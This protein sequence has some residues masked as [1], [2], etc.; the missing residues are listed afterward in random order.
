[1][2]TGTVKWFDPAKGFGF[3]QPEDGSKDVFVHVTAVH[4]AGMD[5]LSEG[6]RVNFE[7]VTERAPSEA[8]REMHGGEFWEDGYFART[9][10]DEVTTE[11]IR[12]YIEYHDEE[13]N[14]LNQLDLFDQ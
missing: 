13:E 6:Q 11:V 8:E 5:T 2:A 3:I 14:R 1:M 9:V 4:A 7:L 12:R 10:G